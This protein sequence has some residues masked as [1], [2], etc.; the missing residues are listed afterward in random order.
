GQQCNGHDKVPF[1]GGV[2]ASDHALDADDHGVHVFF[3]GDD[4]RPQVLVPAIDEL[5]DEQGGDAGARQRE[6]HIF[7]EAHGTGAVDA[8]GLHELVGH[9]HEELAEQ[10]GGRGGGNE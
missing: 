8:R 1:G 2:A 9:R 3:G 4:E 7:E 10:K 6:Q 5:D